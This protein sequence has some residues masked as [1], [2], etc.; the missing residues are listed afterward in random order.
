MKLIDKNNKETNSNCLNQGLEILSERKNNISSLK[1]KINHSNDNLIE[2]FFGRQNIIEG[3]CDD[4][5]LN[6]KQSCLENEYTQKGEA[7]QT[8]IASYGVS[9]TTFLDN[10]Q[11]AYKD[12]SSCRI[13]CNEDASYTIAEEDKTATGADPSLPTKATYK[14]LAK[15]ACVIGCHLKH[16]PEILD[17]SENGIGFKTAKAMGSN[18]ADTSV[19]LKVQVGD[20]CTTI[21]EN[22]VN[23]LDISVVEK[24]QLK[25]ILDEN[26]YNAWDHCCDGKLG[27]KFK[28]YKWSGGKKIKRCVDF[29][30]Q[31]NSAWS[32]G[33]DTRRIA[34]NKGFEMSLGAPKV[35]SDKTHKERYREVIGK[36]DT[37][38]STAQDLLDLVKELKDVGKEIIMERD[39]EVMKFINT[40][41]SYEEVLGD[42]KDESKPKII[43]TLNKNIED[44]VLLKKSTDLRLYVWF[45]LALGF[46]ISAL[47]KIKS[48]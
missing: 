30:E 15:R 7:L 33:V 2:G 45:V 3:F 47:M 4:K 12:I 18:N 8:N 31:E 21:Y 46:G 9:Y 38:S 24:D 48:L 26:N 43:N 41:E 32:S 25:L 14:T 42:I 27:D 28:P 40:N 39:A 1:H 37:I 23:K 44:K 22:V 20:D 35:Q 17:C 29:T 5:P 13:K 34:C 19:G 10:V 16:S 11:N 36:N 6:E